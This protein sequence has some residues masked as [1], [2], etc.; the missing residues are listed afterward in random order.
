[1]ESRKL[2][3]FTPHVKTLYMYI[4]FLYLQR[5]LTFSKGVIPSRDTYKEKFTSKTHRFAI[6][7]IHCLIVNNNFVDMLL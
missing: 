1:M 3:R 5:N 6:S 2:V 4:Y 7:V